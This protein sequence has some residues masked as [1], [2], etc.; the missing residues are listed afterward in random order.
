M[1]LKDGQYRSPVSIA[2]SL[3]DLKN[4]GFKQCVNKGGAPAVESG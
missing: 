3:K 4:V 1:P 2:L